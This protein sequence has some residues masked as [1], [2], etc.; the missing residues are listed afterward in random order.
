M[1]KLV[2]LIIAITLFG[3][4]QTARPAGLAS[5]H[6]ECY[7]HCAE[8]FCSYT[9]L[10]RSTDCHDYTPV[11]QNCVNGVCN[12]YCLKSKYVEAEKK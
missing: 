1:K 4:T 7:S 2:L 5:T 6:E 11:L 10:G 12:C 3:C 9:G 8:K